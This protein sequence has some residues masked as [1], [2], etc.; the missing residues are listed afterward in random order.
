MKKVLFFLAVLCICTVSCTKEK[1]DYEAELETSIPEYGDFEEAYT[2]TSGN[3]KVSIEA[4]NGQLYHGYNDIRL[5]ISSSTG[6]IVDVSEVTFLPIMNAADGRTVSCPHPYI[7]TYMADGNYYSGYSV[8][9]AV[10]S[11]SQTWDLYIGFKVA[12]QVHRVKSSIAVYDQKNKNLN[13]TAFVGNDGEQYY[14]ALVSPQNPKVGENELIAGIYTYNRP[15]SLPSDEFQDAS[16]F[17]YS[18]VEGYTLRLDPRMPEPSMG[19]HSSPNNK[20]LTQGADGMYRGVVNY[21]M[22]GNWTLNFMLIDPKGEIL[23][24]TEV[25]MDHSPGVVGEK[26]ELYIDILF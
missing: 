20:D 18:Q 26:S 24:G 21:T 5:K 10:S 1:T 19:N 3:Y 12:G 15:T 14:I 16:Q 9:T 6:E 7:T 13:M 8:F 2:V 11:A 17:S 4:L 25:P 23:K 22:T